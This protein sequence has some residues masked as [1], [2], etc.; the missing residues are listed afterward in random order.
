M[1]QNLFHNIDYEAIDSFKESKYRKLLA[2][3]PK[4][5]QRCRI[6]TIAAIKMMNHA[7]MGVEKGIKTSATGKPIEVS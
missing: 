6:S 4:H 2:A 7:N 1:S 3:N 5:I